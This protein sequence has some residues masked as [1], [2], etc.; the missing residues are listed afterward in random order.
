MQRHK[1]LLISLRDPFLDSDRIMPPLGVMSLQAYLMEQHIET[2]IVNDFKLDDIGRYQMFTHFGISCMTPE[3]KQAYEIVRAIKREYPDKKVII[4]GPHANYYTDECREEMFDHIVIGDGEVALKHIL[5]GESNDRIVSYPLTEEEMNALP[6]PY[7]EPS[8]LRQY[9]FNMQGLQA[10]TILTAKG[11]PMQCK[12][13]EDAGTKVRLYSADYVG[14]QILQIIRAGYDGVMFFDDIFA[15]SIKRV[16]E[17]SCEIAKYNIHYRCFGHAKSMTEEMIKLLVDSGCIETG[18]GS[19]SGSQKILN[20][21]NKGTTVEQN[22]RYVELCNKYGV[23]VKAFILLGLPGEDKATIKA[24]RDYMKF[25]M[26]NRFINRFGRRI[27]NDFDI[28]IYFPYKGTRIR[29]DIDNGSQEYDLF[30]AC[31]PDSM[32]GVYKGKCGASEA[33]ISTSSLR[34]DEIVSIQKE[35]LAEFKP[36]VVV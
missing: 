32:N 22:M 4:G 7:R 15:L 35:L 3:R 2:D 16:R 30:L 28:T 25:L 8:F 29:D 17:L 36:L 31:D 21:I 19:E 9:S 34:R 10:S 1:I 24:T 26:N 18:F 14:R 13:C 23:K 5:S 6:L 20:L 33:T 27:T 11:C 12:F